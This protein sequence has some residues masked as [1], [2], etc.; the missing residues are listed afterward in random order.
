M[1]LEEDDYIRAR[2]LCSCMM[3]V[4]EKESQRAEEFRDFLAE[5]LDSVQLTKHSFTSNSKSEITTD[6]TILYRLS[7]LSTDIMLFNCEVKNE[8]GVTNCSAPE[9]CLW[10]HYQHLTTRVKEE[11]IE[12][13]CCPAILCSVVGP[14]ISFSI[15]AHLGKGRYVCDPVTPFLPMMVLPHQQDMIVMVAKAL[16]ATKNA[17]R[18]LKLQ[19]DTWANMAPSLLAEVQLDFPYVRSFDYQG[20]RY[21]FRYLESIPPGS[22]HLVYRVCVE[23]TGGNSFPVGTELVVKFCKR[24]SVPAHRAL[25]D[26]IQS[27]LAPSFISCLSIAGG[28]KMV[29]M[30]YIPWSTLNNMMAVDPDVQR[31]I[32]SNLRRALNLLHNQNLVHGDL[33]P[34][35]I[36]VNPSGDIRIVD[37]EHSGRFDGVNAV[38]YPPFLNKSG[39]IQ[40]APGTECN[41]LITREHDTFF[42]NQIFPTLPH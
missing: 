12:R 10:Y 40:W 25:S 33:R 32:L 14:Y 28:W 20:S 2:I 24:Y 3:G 42:Y 5:Y 34:N 6:G 11:L 39:Q 31:A 18:K 29:I 7:P 1:A 30:D 16:R 41:G 35:N 36:L 15:G 19:Y 23:R 37:F 22:H 21:E 9:E 13:C 26:D 17:I 38:R 27:Q 4:F 8:L